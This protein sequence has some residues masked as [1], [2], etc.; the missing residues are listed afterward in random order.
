MKGSIRAVTTPRLPV[1]DRASRLLAAR[2]S[3]LMQLQWPLAAAHISGVCGKYCN[4]REGQLVR[5]SGRV[6]AFG[7]WSTRD[8]D[9]PATPAWI[10]LQRQ[11][12]SPN[13]PSRPCLVP[14]LPRRRQPAGTAPRLHGPAMPPAANRTGRRKQRQ[15]HSS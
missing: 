13:L 9:V 1:V 12:A 4:R 6:L 7:A 5:G 11:S 14:S 3:R 8:H 10:G 2:A 15:I